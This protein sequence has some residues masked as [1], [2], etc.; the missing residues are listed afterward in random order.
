V[1]PVGAG[2]LGRQLHAWASPPESVGAAAQAHVPEST[3][4]RLWMLR[5]ILAAVEEIH[6]IAI[7]MLSTSLIVLPRYLISRSRGYSGASHVS[8]F[9]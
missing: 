5:K 8:Q 1:W 6:R 3:S 2:Q 9:T 7:G 4:I